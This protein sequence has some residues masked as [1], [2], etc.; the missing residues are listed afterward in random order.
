VPFHR[1]D[2]LNRL[3]SGIARI[4]RPVPFNQ[5]PKC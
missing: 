2:A 4:M 5:M 1:P 3:H